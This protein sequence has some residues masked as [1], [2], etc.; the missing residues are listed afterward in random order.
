MII[1]LFLCCILISSSF[2][3]NPE[4]VIID[5][6]NSD[7]YGNSIDRMTIDKNGDI[8]IQCGYESGKVFKINKNDWSISRCYSMTFPMKI[9]EDGFSWHVGADNLIKCIDDNAI[10][11]F[12]PPDTLKWENLPKSIDIDHNGTKWILFRYELYR[13]D[14]M[15]WSIFNKT[16]MGFPDTPANEFWSVVIDEVDNIWIGTERTGLVKYDGTSWS[17]YDTSNSDLPGSSAHAMT[18]DDN[19][20]LWVLSSNL[21]SDRNL[22][23]IDGDSWTLIEIP[24]S[25]LPPQVLIVQPLVSDKNEVKWIGTWAGGLLRFDGKNWELFNAAN[26]G[27][28]DNT[29][30]S[31]V[32]DDY[33]NKWIGTNKG[34][35]AIYNKGGVAGLNHTDHDLIPHIFKLQQN[36]PNPFNPS[37]TIEFTLSK[38]EFVE[39][40]VYNILGKEVSTLVS[41]KLNQGNHTYTFDGK[42]LA[43]GIYYYQLVAGDYREVKKMILLR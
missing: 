39:L 17:I 19:G 37:T 13:F 38:S 10:E 33:G 5:T 23:K 40:K 8:I 22:V 1:F 18:I 20:A 43:S 12:T 32:I 15:N 9:D 7:L 29:I 25:G 35:L 11:F 16:D 14:G 2:T 3:Q 30:W 28:P 21:L 41:K 6:S 42:D 36:Y 27:L 24:L 34:G 4:W 31:M 26:S